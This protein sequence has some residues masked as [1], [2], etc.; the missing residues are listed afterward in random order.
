MID[1]LVAA[2]PFID[3]G[4]ALIRLRSAMPIYKASLCGINNADVCCPNF[5]LCV[6]INVARAPKLVRVI[7]CNLDEIVMRILI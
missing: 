4:N 2:E 5:A 7:T 3:T 6:Q 1:L